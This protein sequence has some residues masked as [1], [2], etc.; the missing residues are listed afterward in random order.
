[1]EK[2]GLL[3]NLHDILLSKLNLIFD[4]SVPNLHQKV[5]RLSCSADITGKRQTQVE[6]D[7]Q[8]EE[9]ELCYLSPANEVLKVIKNIHK[10]T[11]N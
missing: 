2:M 9:G 4:L 7:C 11:K 6:V 5:E 1:M 8:S 3:K 10:I